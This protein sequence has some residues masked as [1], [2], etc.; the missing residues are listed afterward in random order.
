MAS[1]FFEDGYNNGALGLFEFGD[2]TVDEVFG[3]KGAVDEAKEYG[4]GLFGDIFYRSDEGRELAFF[5]IFVY[6]DVR[7]GEVGGFFDGF[8]L[9]SEDD[10]DCIGIGGF[11]DG[12]DLLE[13]GFVFEFKKRLRFSHSLREACC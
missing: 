7:A 4:L 11:K 3:D 12:D 10:G 2:Y 6:D 9:C 8:G 5:V 13:E 1:F